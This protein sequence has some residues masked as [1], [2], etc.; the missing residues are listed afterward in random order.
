[1]VLNHA[2]PTLKIYEILR[3]MEIEIVSITLIMLQFTLI[4]YY[5]PET[6]I[7]VFIAGMCLNLMKR[8]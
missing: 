7:D 4:E 6:V 5:I 3:E 8:K 2:K 1:M